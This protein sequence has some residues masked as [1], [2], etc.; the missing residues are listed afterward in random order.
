MPFRRRHKG[1]R[2][3]IQKMK[4]EFVG[5]LR[6]SACLLALNQNYHASEAVALKRSIRNELRS[7]PV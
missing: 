2:G 5:M 6:H 1:V 4:D 7:D 3:K